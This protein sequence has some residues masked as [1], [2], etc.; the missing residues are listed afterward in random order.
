MNIISKE[1]SPAVT[2]VA[3]SPY[4][5]LGNCT[6]IWFFRYRTI[7]GNFI[8]LTTLPWPIPS[9]PISPWQFLPKAIF[10]PGNSH[11]RQFP[12]QAILTPENSYPRQFPPQPILTHNSNSS[13]NFPA[14]KFGIDLGGNCPGGIVQVGCVWCG[15][16]LEANCPRGVPCGKLSRQEGEGGCLQTKKVSKL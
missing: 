7:K 14:I 3:I 12:P 15:N 8:P 4:L 10:T 9:Q 16:F 2:V 6:K 1:D 11:P 5:Y 13:D